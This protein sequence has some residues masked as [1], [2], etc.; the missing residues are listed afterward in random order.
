MHSKQ[1]A[2]QVKTPTYGSSVKSNKNVPQLDKSLFAE[3]FPDKQYNNNWS[4]TQQIYDG[5]QPPKIL[6]NDTIHLA[7]PVQIVYT[8]QM[9]STSSA[10]ALSPDNFITESTPITWVTKQPQTST[11]NNQQM[12]MLIPSTRKS[13]KTNNNNLQTK[14]N[15]R[16]VFADSTATN[17]IDFHQQS[18]TTTTIIE[19]PQQ[20]LTM[21]TSGLISTPITSA[22]IP[23]IM[24]NSMQIQSIVSTYPTHQQ[25]HTLVPNQI[26]LQHKLPQQPKVIQPN[27]VSVQSSATAVVKPKIHIQHQQIIPANT[28][29]LQNPMQLKAFH[30][31]GNIKLIPSSD[32]RMII[33]GT[34]DGSSLIPSTTSLM[35]SNV[36]HHGTTLNNKVQLQKV[37]LMPSNKH[38]TKNMVVMQKMVLQNK[39]TLPQQKFTTI[40][41]TILPPQSPVVNTKNT[42]V[43]LD[44]SDTDTK[45]NNLTTGLVK[46]VSPS[47]V[48]TVSTPIDD[49]N[50]I[51]EDTPVD[52]ISSD[53]IS[54]ADIL[55]DTNRLIQTLPT[56]NT[57][58][59]S[60]SGG[61]AIL[62]VAQLKPQK[63][64][65]I[66]TI[67]AKSGGRTD[68]G[69][70]KRQKLD[71][72][73][74]I[75]R[76]SSN[77][78][79][80]THA[81]SNNTDWEDELDQSKISKSIN[82][83]SPSVMNDAEDDYIDEDISMENYIC[84]DETTATEDDIIQYEGGK[85]PALF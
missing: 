65:I 6:T 58:S 79:D 78:D 32:G 31:K 76:V 71:K 23:S 10:S 69:T 53:M 19:Q 62:T 70:A 25:Q 45:T 34:I 16:K 17:E 57:A 18:A 39:T 42:V 48:M 61:G 37:Q 21:T 77:Y 24:D 82:I 7:Q 84:E 30:S 55:I 3:T 59:S 46:T 75:S 47:V 35:S 20:Q 29:K 83:F 73:T 41:A 13:N 36:T 5:N 43:V 51:T 85:W 67:T 14:N 38:G 26:V 40:P 8:S 2:K 64:K 49:Q 44:V 80:T 11:P 4:P 81:T 9:E 74:K 60:T 50:V 56:T 66:K 63:H 27:S 22:T 68:I 1:S 33:K 28:V 54:E 15:R 12:K 72:T 52:I